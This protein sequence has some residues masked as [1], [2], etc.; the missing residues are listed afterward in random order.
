[1]SITD[2][3]AAARAAGRIS[4]SLVGDALPLGIAL[5][6]LGSGQLLHLNREAER[7][8][9]LPA[10]AAPLPQPL[11]QA[12]PPELLRACA[13]ERW[14]ALAGQRAPARQMLALAGR[15]G[16]RWLQLQL[17][18]LPNRIGLLCLQDAGAEQQL[19]R[20]LQES[21]TRFREVTEAVRECLFVTTPQWDR[22]HFSSPLLL[23][24]LGLSPVDLRQGLQQLRERI[25]PAD[26]VLYDRRLLM[27]AD[28]GGADLVLR[29]EHPAK[30]L[31][32]L[33]LRTRLRQQAGQALVY[34]ILA[35][36]SDEQRQREELQQARDRAEAASRAKSAFMANMS[37]EFRTPMNGILG[38]TELLLKTGLSAE[39][40][41]QAEVA[42]RCAEDLLRLMDGLLA[43]AQ[44]GEAPAA[45]AAA[46]AE[47]FDPRA[48]AEAALAPLAA[49]AA[50]QGL[51]L[52]LDA[53]PLLPARLIGDAP[54]IAQVLDG[55]LDNALKFTPRGGVRLAVA[56]RPAAA[57]GLLLE[58]EVSDSGIGFDPAEL[59]RLSKP[60][61]QAEAGLARRHAGAGLGLALVQQRVQRMGG[62]LSA[63]RP[64]DGG[65]VFCFSVPV[66]QAPEPAAE[67][68]AAAPRW[69]GRYI[70]VVEDNQVNQEVIFQMLA[71]LGCAVR[72]ADSAHAGLQ[73]LQDERF[74][75]VLMD[76]HMPGM[77]GI[78]A[79][80][81]LRRQSAGQTPPAVPVVAVTANALSGDE[82]R[83]LS[84]GFDDYLPKPFRQSQLL[85]MLSRHLDDNLHD[86]TESHDSSPQAA[87]DGTALVHDGATMSGTPNSD[88]CVLDAQALAR[89]RELDPDG[90]SQLLPRII[91]AY[92]KSLERLL[93]ELAQARG[94]TLDLAVVRHVSHTLKSSSAS[95]GA[96]AL[97]QRCAEI[98]T[99]ARLGHAQGLDPLLDAMLVEI[100]EVRLALTALQNT[101]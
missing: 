49:R 36:V 16:Q 88:T 78:E 92:L 14:Q 79:L 97:S 45:T 7:L 57:G 3:P 19:Q 17:S 26:R 6:D 59:P 29:I 2:D 99:M 13:A 37:H 86:S 27:Q 9:A 75:L 31:R 35:D 25:H 22:L 44:G 33:R 63:R 39:Q 8:L 30:G 34:A 43:Y 23:D 69:P 56:S 70:L 52:D 80:Q 15:H 73:A 65:S 32:W 74:D 55:L 5:L 96:L 67:A 76:I 40:R 95:L 4:A 47:H 42:Q 62:S 46:A 101:P 50:A 54:R 81:R 1:M 91:N 28:G 72:L 93:P 12:L 68:A 20:A 100:A 94:E 38:M 10:A 53:A 90:S 89:L 41:H 24:M 21:D 83:L 51:T 11:Q 87:K 98:E 77:D 61:T 66:R 64:A 85:A 84:H 18:L 58:F 71:H 82:K 48:L 60:F